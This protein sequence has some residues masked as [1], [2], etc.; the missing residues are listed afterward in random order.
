MQIETPQAV[1]I[2]CRL[3][4]EDLDENKID[5]LSRSIQNQKSMLTDFAEING[6]QIFDI[7]CDDNLSGVARDRPEF[8]RLIR[9]ASLRKFNIILCK[10]NRALP[11]TWS[12]WKNTSTVSSQFGVSGS[13]AW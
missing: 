10:T 6:W 9:D 5:N 3:S 1:A 12:S 4:K 7:Y 2:Y 13:S 8:N 11:E